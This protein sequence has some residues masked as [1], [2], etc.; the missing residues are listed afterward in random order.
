MDVECEMELYCGCSVDINYSA[1]DVLWISTLQWEILRLWSILKV[2]KELMRDD[3][4]VE[5]AHREG[6]QQ[7][8]SDESDP[9]RDRECGAPLRTDGEFNDLL[10]NSAA[11]QEIL[12]DD[13]MVEMNLHLEPCIG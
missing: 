7:R 8:N 13:V 6:Q 10:D 12:M 4:V 3:K 9:V 5:E 11:V 2:N 1:G